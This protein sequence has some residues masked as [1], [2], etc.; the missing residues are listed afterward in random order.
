MVSNSGSCCL[1][2]NFFGGGIAV[3]IGGEGIDVRGEGE[4]GEHWIEANGRC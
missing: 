2:L 4:V 3:V 1:K